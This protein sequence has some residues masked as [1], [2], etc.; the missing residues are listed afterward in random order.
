MPGAMI[1]RRLVAFLML[2]AVFGSSVESLLG[3]LRDGQVHHE[4]AATA[5]AHALKAQGD[6]GHEDAGSLPDHPDGGRHE[7]GTS[8]D[9]CTHQHGTA[10]PAVFA[11]SLPVGTLSD[12]LPEPPV[13]TGRLARALFHPPRA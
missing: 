12:P 6:H 7:H 8:A 3:A 5:A 9:H 13:H 1:V 11:F 10:L 2:L 4:T